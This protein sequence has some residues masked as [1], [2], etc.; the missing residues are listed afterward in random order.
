MQGNVF[1]KS[2]AQTLWAPTINGNYPPENSRNV[3]NYFA[4]GGYTSA[5]SESLGFW[6]GGLQAANGGIINTIVQTNKSDQAN[7]TA[8]NL[9]KVDMSSPGKALWRNLTWPDWLQPRAEGGL[10]WL[11]YGDQGILLAFGGVDLPGDQGLSRLLLTPTQQAVTNNYMTNIAVYD[12]AK[13]IWALQPT[14]EKTSPSQMAQFCTVTASAADNSSQFIYVYGGYDGTFGHD[15]AAYD[16]IWVLSVPA[17]QWTKLTDGTPNH[18]RF[19]HTCVLP[20]PTQ[21]LSI[22]GGT[23]QANLVNP[24]WLDVYDL[25][26]G[27]W[28]HFYN[29]SSTALYI[30]PSAITNQIG[31]SA[32]GG[33]TVPS[34]LND[35]VTALLNTKYRK[36]ITGYSPYNYC[37]PSTTSDPP[38]HTNTTITPSPSTV[39]KT[40]APSPTPAWQ[41]P[42]IATLSTIAGLAILGALFFFFCHWRRRKSDK[43][44]NN[45]RRSIISWMHKSNLK[46]PPSDPDTETTAV[47]QSDCFSMKGID[48]T[49]EM[50]SNVTSPGGVHGHGTPRV[51]SSPSFGGEMESPIPHEIMTHPARDSMSIGQHPYYPHSIQGD[52]INHSVRSDSISPPSQSGVPSTLSAAVNPHGSMSP[53]ELAHGQ[54]HD[55]LS[56]VPNDNVLDISSAS[57]SVSGA[58][59]QIHSPLPTI[60]A[61]ARKP[62]S[63]DMR[64]VTPAQH[65]PTAD[66]S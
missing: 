44:G 2:A 59:Q 38:T 55:N 60:P 4:F 35:T 47:N 24:D 22:G 43:E 6:F 40:S 17:F 18:R 64:P 15:K 20:N 14:Q 62:V 7:T 63:P 50:P 42:V 21:M 61:V 12:I 52:F 39:T 1:Q 32:S 33:F 8:K 3:S 28:T 31:G 58:N 36:Q 65:G 56:H 13:D 66:A 9:V 25:N 54:S 45:K 30:V 5:P 29:S 27:A 46:Q 19:R 16:S 48:K 53:F 49:Y 23:D 34:G 26:V 11:P 57:Q 51:V 37:T 10:V 41:T